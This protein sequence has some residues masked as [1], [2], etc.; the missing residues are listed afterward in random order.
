MAAT[1]EQLAMV[2]YPD[3]WEMKEKAKKFQASL[4]PYSLEDAIKEM[5]ARGQYRP[6]GLLI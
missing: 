4:P 1:K 5:K 3:F 2:P 6:T